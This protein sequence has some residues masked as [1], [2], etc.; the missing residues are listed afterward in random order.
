MQNEMQSEDNSKNIKFSMH[1]CIIQA[2]EEEVPHFAKIGISK[3]NERVFDK[4]H[5]VFKDWKENPPL[6]TFKSDVSLW[7]LHRFVK[8]SD[9]AQ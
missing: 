7:K 3:L 2:R 9:D 6:P 1:R 5:S 8:D 4:E